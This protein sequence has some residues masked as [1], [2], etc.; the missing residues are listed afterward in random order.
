MDV[1]NSEKKEIVDKANKNKRIV[2]LLTPV[3]VAD[4]NQ[5]QLTLKFRSDSYKNLEKE[6]PYEMTKLELRTYYDEVSATLT[7]DTNITRLSDADVIPI[8][9][10]DK[11]WCFI[12]N[13]INNKCWR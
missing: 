11:K 3:I 12:V 8:S 7:K 9:I 6:M 10:E 2:R 1:L 13:N 5:H 4:D